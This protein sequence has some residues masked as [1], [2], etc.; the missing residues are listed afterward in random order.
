QVTLLYKKGD[1]QDPANYIPITLLNL[2]AKLGPKILARRLGHVRPSLLH[3]D[4]CGF[5]PGRDIRHAHF[6]FQALQQL[7]QS[8]HSKAGA[9]LLDFAKAFDT[10]N[11]EALQMVLRHFNFGGA[12]REWIKILFQGTLVSLFLPGHHCLI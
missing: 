3:P 9:V 8:S 10:V 4:Q 5:V 1:K 11:W 7:C 12:F 2:D 6:R